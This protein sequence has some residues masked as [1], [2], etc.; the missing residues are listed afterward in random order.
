[1]LCCLFCFL[2]LTSQDVTLT[3]EQYTHLV[4]MAKFWNRGVIAEP[5][6]CAFDPDSGEWIE[7]W[8]GKQLFSEICPDIDYHQLSFTNAALQ[9]QPETYLTFNNANDVLTLSK[10]QR[11]TRANMVREILLDKKVILLHGDLLCGRLDASCLANQMNSFGH[12]I[13]DKHGVVANARFTSDVQRMG[14]EDLTYHGGLSIG[15]MDAGIPIGDQIHA[16][17]ETFVNFLNEHPDLQISDQNSAALNAAIEAKLC[18]LVAELRNHIGGLIR[19]VSENLCCVLMYVSFL[20]ACLLDGLNR[21]RSRLNRLRSRLNRLRS[22]LNHLRSRLD[23]HRPPPDFF[24]E[25]RLRSFALA[26]TELQPNQ[27]PRCPREI[28]RRRQDN[29]HAKSR[30]A[31]RCLER[32]HRMA[33]RLESSCLRKVSI[34]CDKT[35]SG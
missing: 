25:S 29:G 35:R 11:A 16:R 17:V 7:R 8:T 28:M 20:Y 3:R 26:L 10:Q 34:I 27:L 24:S 21:L 9:Q 6:I 13:L 31:S 33:S 19:Q 12:V 1:V 32:G 30:I 22:H 15:V 18:S 4:G 5:A 2:Q 14:N 23:L